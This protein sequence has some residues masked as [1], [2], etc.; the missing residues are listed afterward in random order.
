MFNAPGREFNAADARDV[1]EESVSRLRRGEIRSAER[2]SGG[3]WRANAW[4]SRGFCSVFARGQMVEMRCRPRTCRFFD[5]DTFRLR[6]MSLD[7]GVRIVMGGSDHQDGS[8]LRG[9]LSSFRR[10]T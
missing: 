4:V 5:K 8:M 9:A 6:P 7:D 10:L 2:D 1:F 3:T